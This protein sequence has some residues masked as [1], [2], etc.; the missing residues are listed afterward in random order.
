[1]GSRRRRR[2][3]RRRVVVWRALSPPAAERLQRDTK[4]TAA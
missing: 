3:R 1:M 2:R 4:E